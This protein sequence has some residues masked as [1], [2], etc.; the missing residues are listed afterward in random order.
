MKKQKVWRKCLFS[1]KDLGGRKEQGTLKGHRDSKRKNAEGSMDGNRGCLYGEH[2]SYVG[3]QYVS[4][5]SDVLEGEG[6]TDGKEVLEEL[7]KFIQ[8]Q[9]LDRLDVLEQV[10]DDVI[11]E[12]IDEEILNSSKRWY[13][14]MEDKQRLRKEIFAGIR[15]LDVLQQLVDDEEITEIMINGYQ[16]IFIEKRGQIYHSQLTFS[17]REK[18]EDVIQQMVS[19][20]NRTVNE[21]K[22]IVD[23]RLP[24]GSRVHVVLAP[25]ALNGPAVTIRKFPKEPLTME[26]LLALGAVT[27]KACSFLERVILSRYNIFISGGTGSGK[28]TLLG[29]L[30]G[31]IPSDERVITIED[32]AEL[33]IANIS[34]LVSMETRDKNMEGS[35]EIGMEELI[36]AALRMRPDRL[37]VG[38]VRDSRAVTN[39]LQ[40]LNTGHSG[41]STGHAN[42]AKD[43]LSRLEALMLTGSDMPI[44][45]ARKQIAS[46]IDIIIHL[47]RM[48]D[49]TRRVLEI[50][51]IAGV[52]Q[53]EIVMHPLFLWDEETKGLIRT[54]HSLINVQKLRMSGLWR[55]EG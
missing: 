29:A 40:A 26:R 19:R 42:S 31:Y 6:R 2:G 7:R 53:G 13:M 39:M 25:T 20:V 11:L 47:G 55:E 38:E 35:I 17:T 37:I 49:R 51:E 23:A 9:V 34:N 10:P 44:L 16:S 33:Q 52:E 4:D 15:G 5:D 46:A 1:I 41:L 27:K 50:S 30:A 14:R 48:K 45:A 8:Q 3:G 12:L 54:K 21:A 43:M 28:T 36:K 22:P 24:D 32:S 18:L